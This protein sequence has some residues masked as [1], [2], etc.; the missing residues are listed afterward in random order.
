MQ[1]EDEPQEHEPS[2]I[3]VAAMTVFFVGM[4]LAALAFWVAAAIWSDGLSG[5]MTAIGPATVTIFGALHI[6][7]A[8]VG[9]LLWQWRRRA[10][11]PT[12]RVMLEAATL[13][14]GGVVLISIFA[15][16]LAVSLLDALS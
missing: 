3:L 5:L 8:I 10:I 13:Y 1:E 12:H 9:I 2:P 11:S 4:T 7:A 14:F 6:P 15:N 16:Y